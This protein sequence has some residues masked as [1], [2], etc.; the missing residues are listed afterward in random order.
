[1]KNDTQPDLPSQTG[2][3]WWKAIR[4]SLPMFVLTAVILWG[5]KLPQDGLQAAIAVFC[6][7]FYNLCFLLMMKTGRTDRYR[8]CLFTII[9]VGF[10]LSFFYNIRELQVS[11]SRSMGETPF[12]L[13]PFE[14]FP[15]AFTRAIIFPVSQREGFA[16]TSGMT[17]IGAIASL[18][19][20][21]AWC[22][23]VCFFGGCDERFARFV[24]KPLLPEID[25]RWRLMPYA[26]LAVL[27]LLSVPLHCEWMC[28]FKEIAGG[29]E[30]SAR[31]VAVQI[32][33]FG[34]VLI[35]LIT[36]LSVLTR[37]R[38]Q[39]GLLCPSGA[40]QSLI[41]KL[42]PFEVRIDR[43][44]CV[45]CG[46]CVADCPTFSIDEA[47]VKAGRTL[48]NCTKCGRC[49]DL[50]PRGAI[51]YHIKG[52]LLHV[53]TE[54]ARVI[55]LYAAFLFMYTLTNGTVSQALWLIV[56]GIAPDV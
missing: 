17:V 51:G 32:L 54:R 21:R 3:L 37:R 41:N 48:F 8:A 15:A 40:I 1:M 5:V 36:V 19:L 56:K 28:P 25:R 43:D 52:T 20:G 7:V 29:P 46:I 22:S 39:C 11:A 10:L 26:V 49:I 14:L 18:A 12:Y 2:Q 55:F 4:F 13:I 34:A 33:L 44:K 31:P 16:A 53:Q 27:A 24:R 38:I 50:C 9:G 6:W 35:G 30:I 42:N 23:W 45:D 47:S